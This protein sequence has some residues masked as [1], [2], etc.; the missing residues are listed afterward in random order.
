[1]CISC[2]RFLKW[3]R[4]ACFSISQGFSWNF[5]YLEKAMFRQKK[6]FF[7]WSFPKNAVVPFLWVFAAVVSGCAQK[8]VF[9]GDTMA[10]DKL[11]GEILQEV[12]K[13]FGE[14]TGCQAIGQATASVDDFVLPS[15]GVRMHALETWR[16]EGCGKVGKFHVRMGP[17]GRDGAWFRVS[18]ENPRAKP[19]PAAAGDEKTMG[20]A[21]NKREKAK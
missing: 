21:W 3:G 14:A 18:M 5:V 4:S 2:I 15:K 8:Q 20:K 11:K 17:E 7:R 12:Q 10:G 16:V 19:E 13:M 6:V 9:W 1:M